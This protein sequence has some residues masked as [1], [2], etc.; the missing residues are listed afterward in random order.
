MRNLLRLWCT[1][2]CYPELLDQTEM[3]QVFV[4]VFK[5]AA[6]IKASEAAFARFAQLVADY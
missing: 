3:D 4:S 2:F 5:P 1:P 6:G